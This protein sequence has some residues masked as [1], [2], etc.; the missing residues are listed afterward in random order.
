ML[1]LLATE[2]LLLV[3]SCYWL[4]D[5]LGLGLIISVLPVCWGIVVPFSVLIY[6]SL[7]LPLGML[8][9]VGVITNPES[10]VATLTS[11]L[12]NCKVILS[13]FRAGNR[14]GSF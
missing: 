6:I 7:G 13:V 4:V 2:V 9:P 5:G 11:G 12:G 3:H 14:Y 8:V 10:S 1:R